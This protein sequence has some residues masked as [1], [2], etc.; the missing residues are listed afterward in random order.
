MGV[1]RS[2]MIVQKQVSL[3]CVNSLEESSYLKTVAK[4]KVKV[5]TLLGY[6]GLSLS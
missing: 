4:A 2:S 6:E 1:I 5:K 3:I